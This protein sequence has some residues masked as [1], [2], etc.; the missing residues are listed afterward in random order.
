MY[1]LGWSVRIRNSHLLRIPFHQTCRYLH[2]LLSTSLL[3][4]HEVVRDLL[5]ISPNVMLTRSLT[6]EKA[7][8]LRAKALRFRAVDH[9]LS[10]SDESRIQP[11]KAFFLTEGAEPLAIKLLHGTGCVVYLSF[12]ATVHVM[13]LLDGSQ[14]DVWHPVDSQS[15]RECWDVELH[16]DSSVNY[17]L[18]VS[19]VVS[20]DRE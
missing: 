13:S 7:R 14:V 5:A 1:V 6:V 11:A 16:V 18:L 2:D 12:S 19:A 15:I 3:L 17:G 8:D 10:M 20:L 9:I 4:W